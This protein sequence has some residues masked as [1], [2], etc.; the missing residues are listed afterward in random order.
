ML[1]AV[2]LR[3]LD[4][5]ALAGLMR[6]QELRVEDNVIRG[7]AAPVGGGGTGGPQLRVLHL[8]RNRLVDATDCAQKL[9]S[10]PSLLEVSVAG[11]PFARKQVGVLYKETCCPVMRGVTQVFAIAS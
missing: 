6:L 2:C 7:L 11:N 9:A 5:E 4:P 10:M 3:V 1:P 8:G